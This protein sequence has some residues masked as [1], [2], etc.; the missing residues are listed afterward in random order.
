M[1]NTTHSIIER[2]GY[3]YGS[4]AILRNNVVRQ[5]TT[6]NE[7]NGIHQ[8]FVQLDPASTYKFEIEG[9]A[10]ISNMWFTIAPFLE[11]G[12]R[13]ALTL[14]KMLRYKKVESLSKVLFKIY[15]DDETSP[16][17]KAPFGDFFG[18]NFG[19]YR[20]YYSKY[21]GMTCGGYVC[22]FPMP[23]Q[24]KCRIEIENTNIELPITLFYGAVTYTLTPNLAN[25]DKIGYFHAR[26]REECTKP[27][28]PYTILQASGQ[29]HYIGTHLN[30]MNT[31][32]FKQLISLYYL[33]GDCNIYVDGEETP[34]VPYTATEDYCMGGW[35]YNKGPFCAPTHGLTLRGQRNA[36]FRKIK[37]CQYRFHFPDAVNF[38]KSI[39]VTIN[40]GEWNQAP[41]IHRS[42][43]YWYQKEPHSDFFDK[44][45]EIK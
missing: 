10:V 30:I 21:L 8:D 19:E 17:V 6:Q 24:N 35:Y 20:H 31:K 12:W 7:K 2:L 34:S 29:G 3:E 16:S 38:Q 22:T 45:E 5:V 33:E 37:S 39:K 42:V 23:F 25:N 18:C 27:G 15:F 43:A 28:I 26:Y 9:P 11:K 32:R 36:I 44:N 13:K 40:H 1:D 4:I 14:L 41:T